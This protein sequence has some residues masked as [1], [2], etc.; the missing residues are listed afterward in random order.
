MQQRSRTLAEAALASLGMGLTAGALLT[1]G[2]YATGYLLNRR[3]FRS[4]DRDWKNIDIRHG[5]SGHRPDQG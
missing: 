4:W 3:R 1:G 2:L 5:R